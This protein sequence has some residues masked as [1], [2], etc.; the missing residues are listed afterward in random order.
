MSAVRPAAPSRRTVRDIQAR[1]GGEPVVCLTAYT[2]PSARLLD[3]HVDLLL[4]GDS[5]G[6][7][8]YGMP[9]TLGVTLDMMIAHGQAVMRGSDR[10]LVVVDM[11]FGSVQESPA[12]AFRNAARVLAETG[13]AAVKIEGGREMAETVAFLVARGVPVMGHVGLRPQMV[14]AMGG[15]RAQGRDDAGAQALMDD[16]RAIAEA[17]AFSMVVEGTVVD[18]AERVTEA[19]PVPTIGIGASVA[20]DGQILVAEDMLGL[21]QDFTPRFVKKYADLA[22]ATDA[23]VAAY[24]ADV[25]AR[26]FPGPEHTFKGAK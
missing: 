18:V 24:A 21:F 19:V 17:G 20:C 2:T 26:R 22:G 12:L 16:A 8:L 7:V 11:P 4:V 9:T 15:F 5:L 6:M 10:A 23:A 3:P 13:A 1:K 14:H 25:R